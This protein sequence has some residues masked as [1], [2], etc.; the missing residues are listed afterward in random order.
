MRI[1]QISPQVPVPTTDGGKISIFGV[2]KALSR[3]GH[4]LD[5]VTYRKHAELESSL[6]QIEPFAQPHILDV[7]TDNHLLGAISNLISLIPYNVSKYHRKELSEFIL[8]YLADSIPDIILINNLHMGWIIKEIKQITNVP[9][10][11][12]QENVEMIIMKRFFENQRNILLKYFA[13]IQYEKFKS[14]EPKLC[15]LF[16]HCAMV[17]KSDEE[18]LLSF[19]KRIKS[20]VIPVGVDSQL[21]K[22]S[23]NDIEEYSLVHIGHLDWIPNYDGLTW[24]IKDILPGII[25]VQ[26]KI[27]LYIYCGSKTTL[28]KVPEN[29]KNNVEVVDFVENIWQELN[30]KALAI[31]PLRIGSGI[32]VKILEMLAIGQN[33][34]T[35]SLGKEGIEANDKEHLLIAD[36]KDEFIEKILQYFSNKFE[37]EKMSRT[38]KELIS[39]RYTWEIIGEKF[40]NLFVELLNIKRNYG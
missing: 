12:R 14:Y 17:T 10:V 20:S 2:T 21:L 24:F 22:F 3:R 29:V 35:T 37:N 18:R 9:V 11:L 39:Q 6:K 13:K 23:K 34:I 27:K 25:S 7:Q 28:F 40:E 31:V 15:E 36:S 19:N 30:N 16:D 33:I 8:K 26:P 1:L 5:F 32:R 38:G 4:Q